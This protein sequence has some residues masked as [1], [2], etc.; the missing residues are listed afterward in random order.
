[1]ISFIFNSNLNLISPYSLNNI[2]NFNHFNNYNSNNNNNNNIN[3][4]NNNN[5]NNNN[6]YNINKNNNNNNNN[7]NNINLKEII[8]NKNI[9]SMNQ[10]RNYSIKIKGINNNNMKELYKKYNE[11]EIMNKRSN[12]EITKL[13]DLIIDKIGI[14]GE[15]NKVNKEIILN[16]VEK[17]D[18][19]SINI[20][21]YIN[22]SINKILGKLN[23]KGLNRENK[24][25]NK[26]RLL[27]GEKEIEFKPIQL[28]Y[29]YNNIDILNN[30]NKRGISKKMRS[31]SRKYKFRLN[32]RI[33]LIN[34]KIIINKYNNYNNI[35]N[36]NN[37]KT[38]KLIKNNYINSISLNLNN[39]NKLNK[40][41]NLLLNDIKDYYNFKDNNILYD[42]LRYKNIIGWSLLIKGKTGWRKGKNRSNKSFIYKGSFKNINLLSNDL[43]HQRFHLNYL[44]NSKLNS[45]IS[46]NTNNGKLGINMTINII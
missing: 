1:M 45:I 14:R 9:K 21:N 34:P 41:S 42:E 33:N 13:T 30:I 22:W 31:L 16:K 10:I 23:T 28:K 8:N 29:E 2:N 36:Y 37:L 44:P 40:S 26:L 15:N 43:S 32:K 24:L 27:I 18:K 5:N 38:F 7:N 3:I 11:K 19:R 12:K 46:K 39:N 17:L 35:N 20:L 6:N 25:D 4:N